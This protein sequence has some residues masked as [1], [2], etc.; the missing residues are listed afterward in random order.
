MNRLIVVRHGQSEHHV[1]G[2]TGG[3][4]DTELTPLGRDQAL[5][6]AAL[7]REL[8]ADSPPPHLYSSDLLRA[9]QTADCVAAV[10]GWSVVAEPALREIN[11]GVAV[12]LTWQEAKR[13]EL[14][15]TEPRQHW[16]TYPGAET[17][18]SMRARVISGM[19]RIE[20]ECPLTAVVVT[21]G[22]AAVAVIQ[23]WLRLCEPCSAGVSFELDAA[24]ISVLGTNSHGERTIERLNDCGHLVGLTQGLPAS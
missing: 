2:L 6:A 21:H 18:H 7:C 4:T 1:Q 13:I 23:W 12:G 20:L 5:A 22:I 3:W 8:L 15:L 14:P 19:E 11:N 9:A 10:C 24:S 16:R 17:L